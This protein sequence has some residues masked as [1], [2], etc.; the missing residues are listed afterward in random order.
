MRSITVERTTKETSITIS[1]HVP[2]NEEERPSAKD[3]LSITTGVPFLDHMLEGML[4]HGGF[5]GTITASGDTQIDDHHTVE[6]VGIVLGQVFR[7]VVET[8]GPIARYGHAVVPMDDALAETVVDAAGRSFLV[9]RVDFPQAYAGH[10][11]LALVR[12][13]FQG[14]ANNAAINLHILGHYGLNGHHLAEA[15]FKSTGRALGTAYARVDAVRSTKGV[16]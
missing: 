8:H 4:F 7:A 6:D 11:D 12:E 10:F 14:F 2:D 9:F 5:T 15:I 13:F 1:L 3:E 16:L